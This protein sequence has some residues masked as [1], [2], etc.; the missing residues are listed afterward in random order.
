MLELGLAVL[1]TVFSIWACLQSYWIVVPFLTLFAIGFFYTSIMSLKETVN[2]KVKM[3][4]NLPAKAPTALPE[5]SM[6]KLIEGPQ[7]KS[8]QGL[9]IS[10]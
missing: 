5:D 7:P 4:S 9:A 6:P 1:Y 10:Q 2:L 8:V 3:Q